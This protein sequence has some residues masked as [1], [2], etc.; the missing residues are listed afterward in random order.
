MNF[1]NSVFAGFLSMISNEAISTVERRERNDCSVTCV[2]FILRSTTENGRN[3]RKN[4]CRIKRNKI[5]L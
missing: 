5:E 3:D 1:K 4:L 2:P